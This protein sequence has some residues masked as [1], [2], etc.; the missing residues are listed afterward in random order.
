MSWPPRIGEPLPRA[1]EA[2]GVREKL[3]RY[4]L[5]AAHPS[6]GPKAALFAQLLGITVEQ[7]EHLAR[8]IERALPGHPVARSWL[9][10]DGTAGCGVLIPARGVH[11]HDAR[12]MPV[13]TGW[14][15]R[16]LGDRPRLVT[17]YI[18]GR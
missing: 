2:V 1:A 14:E 12:V 10:A 18:K 7:V 13:T 11:I 16:Y 4:S 9:K 5:A 8:E 15:L 3:A 6:G 17:A